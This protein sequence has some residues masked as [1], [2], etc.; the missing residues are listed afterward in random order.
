[1][2]PYLQHPLLSSPIVRQLL[3]SGRSSSE[4]DLQAPVQKGQAKSLMRRSASVRG[5]CKGCVVE[6]IFN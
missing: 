5:L 3:S 6:T 1:M 2:V 4:S